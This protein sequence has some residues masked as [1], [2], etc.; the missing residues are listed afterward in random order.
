MKKH[1]LYVSL[2]ALSLSNVSHAITVNKDVPVTAIVENTCTVGMTDVDMGVVSYSYDK[3]QLG[4]L[5]SLCTK[6]LPYTISITGGNSATSANR[7]LKT[8]D[9][10]SDKLNY[11]IGIV[12]STNRLVGDGLNNTEVIPGVG[13]GSKV[14]QW[15]SVI[16]LRGQYVKP[17][18]YKDVLQVNITY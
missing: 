18:S 4:S 12:G 17:G 14:S 6:S 13:T 3:V 9:M 7:Y 10:S 1:I 5:S 15:L 11:Y 16:I 2:L 8:E